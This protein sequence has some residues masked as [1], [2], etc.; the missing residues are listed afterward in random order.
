MN[1]ENA[2]IYRRHLPKCKFSRV[3]DSWSMLRCNCPIYGDGYI[4]GKRVLRKSLDTRNQAIASMRLS[5]LM[6]RYGD[7][8]VAVAEPKSEPKSISAAIEAF[9][10]QHGTIDE[11]GYHRH[12][13]GFPTYRKYR[14]SL[15]KL[16]TFCLEKSIRDLSDVRLE[17]LDDFRAGR[18]IGR[19]TDRNELQVFRKFW[20]FCVRRKWVR[21]NVAKDADAP[22]NIPD[23]EIVPYTPLEESRILSACDSFGRSPYE[24]LRA[25]AMTQIHRFTALAISDVATLERSRV[26][27]DKG[28]GYWKVM[29]RRQKTGTPVFLPIPNEVK[30]ALD[31]LPAPRGAAIDSPF[32]FWNGVTSK[33]AVV[34]IA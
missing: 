12:S 32:F 21:E 30:M 10:A 18:A 26:E 13:V 20:T 29:V 19:R 22:K 6:A 3:K 1:E 4:D 9:L 25:K 23:N 24:R 7:R 8:E 15:R 33:R 27:W 16:E 11:K 5:E 34:G 14:N 17:Q 31:A 2:R 28:R